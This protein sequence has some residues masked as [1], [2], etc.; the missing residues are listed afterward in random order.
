MPSF[1]LSGLGPGPQ[2]S[3]FNRGEAGDSVLWIGKTGVEESPL[4]GPLFQSGWGVWSVLL[5]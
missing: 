5:I 3:S 1:L 4:D 2:F